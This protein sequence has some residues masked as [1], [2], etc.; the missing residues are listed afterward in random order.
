VH[1]PC[2][3]CPLVRLTLAECG[4]ALGTAFFSALAEE[5]A[6]GLD[7]FRRCTEEVG[8]RV[9]ALMFT[10]LTSAGFFSATQSLGRCSLTRVHGQECA[11]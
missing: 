6:A 8:A 2:Q 3:A 5:A 11:G 4:N 9:G 1:P 10:T 7:D